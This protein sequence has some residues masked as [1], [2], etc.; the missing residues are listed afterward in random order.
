MIRTIGG[1]VA[2]IKTIDCS[3]GCKRNRLKRRAAPTD[4][5][6]SVPGRE[7]ARME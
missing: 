5:F 6:W 7:A 4:F 1:F 3:I 2:V